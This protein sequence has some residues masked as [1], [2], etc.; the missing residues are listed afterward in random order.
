MRTTLNLNEELVR[1][2]KQR[3][4][5]EDRTLTSVIE[6][7]L[8][9]LLANSGALDRR[10]PYAVELMVRSDLRPGLDPNDPAF[11]KQIIEQDDFEKYG[12]HTQVGTGSSDAS[13]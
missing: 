7:A 2:A 13:F 1:R 4:A 3:A 8:R 11:Y 5:A 10:E 6:D 12:P 9:R